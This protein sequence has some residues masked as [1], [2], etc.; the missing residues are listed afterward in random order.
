MCAYVRMCAFVCV[1]VCIYKLV[2]IESQ[3]LKVGMYTEH[4]IFI[5][6]FHTALN[7]DPSQIAMTYIYLILHLPTLCHH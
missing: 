4:Q 3:L 6:L 5:S 7:E 1:H 2:F